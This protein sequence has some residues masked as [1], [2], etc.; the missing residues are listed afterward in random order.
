MQLKGTFLDRPDW[1]SSVAFWY[2][3]P[4]VSAKEPLPAAG[5]RIAPYRVLG[6]RELAVRATPDSGLS[7]APGG[8]SYTPA[9]ADARIEIGFSVAKEGRYQVKAVLSRS[10]LGGRYQPLLDGKPLG[11]ELDLCV[12]GQDT[13]PIN[14]DLHDFAAG[15]HTLSF[16]GRG[17]S[18]SQRTMVRPAYAF[19]LNYLLL[20]R[21]QDLAGYER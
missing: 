7:K 9:V 19:G 21:L 17:V 10:L 6:V 8:I 15:P 20:L 14:F 12:A 1:L 2:Q 5:K 18:A 4:P 16:E 11:P 3:T 13:V